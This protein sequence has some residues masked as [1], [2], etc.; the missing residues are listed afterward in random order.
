MTLASDLCN[1]H[2]SASGCHVAS[3]KRIVV[4]YQADVNN[5]YINWHCLLLK[6]AS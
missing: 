1:W 6:I 4:K 2:T 5:I 3:D